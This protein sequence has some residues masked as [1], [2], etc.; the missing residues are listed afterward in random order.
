M[1]DNFSNFLIIDSASSS[2]MRIGV[3]L[4]NGDA[5]YL[6]MHDRFKYS[7]SIMTMI[8]EVLHRENLTLN[9]LKGIIISTGPGSFTGLRV[10]MAVAKGLAVSLKIPLLGISIFN[11]VVERIYANYKETAV[12]IPSRREEYYLGFISDYHFNEK[13]IKVVAEIELKAN[14]GN[15]YLFAVDC[16]RE[17]MGSFCDK[18]IEENGPS[19]LDFLAAGMK[20]LAQFGSDDIASL[21]PL[22]VQ[23]FPTRKSV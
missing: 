6:E 18:I 17:K 11:A 14:I 2:V 20:K 16:D 5:P 13:G 9:S 22:Y 1:T 19:I 4:S 10:G 15:A 7:E 3:S 23:K 8:D 21:E 12:V